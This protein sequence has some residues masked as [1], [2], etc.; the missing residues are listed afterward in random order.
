MDQHDGI[1]PKAVFIGHRTSYGG[2]Y[3]IGVGVLQRTPANLV[4]HD[5]PLLAV[6]FNGERGAAIGR[7]SGMTLLNRVLQVVGII[8]LAPHNDHVGE[9]TGDVQFSVSKEAQI[10]RA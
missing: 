9:T 2:E 5:E 8:V 4:D 10:A 7:K 1:G 3:R 6:R